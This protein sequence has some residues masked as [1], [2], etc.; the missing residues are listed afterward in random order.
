M[1]Q[2]KVLQYQTEV[3]RVSRQLSTTVVFYLEGEAKNETIA[4]LKSNKFKALLSNH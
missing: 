3:K 1:K 2:W 4:L